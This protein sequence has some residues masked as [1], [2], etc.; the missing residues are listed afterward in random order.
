MRENAR[1][2]RAAGGARRLDG[3]LEDLADRSEGEP[4]SIDGLV[5][6]IIGDNDNPG[7][8]AGIGQ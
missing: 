2:S 4:G 7:F 5:A 3:N 8:H 1:D 6:A